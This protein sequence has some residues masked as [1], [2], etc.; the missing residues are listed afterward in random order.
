MI[1]ALAACCKPS[2]RME[3]GCRTFV[4]GVGAARPG[5]I[6]SEP[7]LRSFG[8]WSH[9]KWG[10]LA[11]RRKDGRA[12]LDLLCAQ[13]PRTGSRCS[14]GFDAGDKTFQRKQV[15]KGTPLYVWGM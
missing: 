14:S 7:C 4:H 6:R 10:G 8:N 9:S 15:A 1:I 13:A 12:V 5:A 3:S 2:S 11:A